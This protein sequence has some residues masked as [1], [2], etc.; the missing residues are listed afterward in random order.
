VVYYESIII[1]VAKIIKMV[2][3]EKILFNVNYYTIK[4]VYTA[5]THTEE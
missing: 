4:D 1:Y 2:Y 3:K 5:K